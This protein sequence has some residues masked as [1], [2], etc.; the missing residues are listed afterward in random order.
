M[1]NRV[2]DALG[3]VDPLKIRFTQASLQTNAPKAIV[4]RSSNQ[5]VSEMLSGSLTHTGTGQMSTLFYEKLDVSIVELETKKSLKITWT[6]VSNKDEVRSVTLL[7]YTPVPNESLTCFL[8]FFVRIGR[9]PTPS[10]SRR[11]RRWTSSA[12]STSQRTSPCRPK[13]R[14]ESASSRSPMPV[15]GRIETTEGRRWL[16]TCPRASRS[17]LR[18]VPRSCL[19][20]S[21]PQTQGGENVD[22]V[23]VRLSP[24]YRRFRLRSWTCK[25]ARHSFRPSTFRRSLRVGTVSPSDSSSSRFVPS[26]DPTS[27]PSICCCWAL[28]ADSFFSPSLSSLGLYFIQGEKFADTKKR[29]QIRTGASSKDFAKYRFALILTDTSGYKQPN[30]IE[31]EDEISEHKFTNTDF[32][33]IDHQ[34]KSGKSRNGGVVEKAIHIR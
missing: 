19:S 15:E 17:T 2:A 22:H 4:K 32:L 24:S 5:N 8:T 33:G 3:G 10:F 7:S 31:D 14:V 29:I 16:E 27:S 11:R 21:L 25:R 13:A 18:H 1:A 26:I 12:S 28:S 30:A 9:A 34:D 23:L 20:R 6:G